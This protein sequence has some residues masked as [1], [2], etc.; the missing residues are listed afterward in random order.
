M[1]DEFRPSQDE[2][3]M[4]TAEKMIELWDRLSPEKQTALL[5][6]FGTLENALAALITTQLVAP[7]PR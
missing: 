5:T 6:R 7:S 1:T 3:L 2:V 4:G